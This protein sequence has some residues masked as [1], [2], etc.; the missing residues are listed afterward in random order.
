MNVGRNNHRL[1]PLSRHGHGPKLHHNV[2]PIIRDGGGFQPVSKPQ[3]HTIKFSS[4]HWAAHEPSVLLAAALVG[5]SAG[6]AAT[7]AARWRRR[8]VAKTLTA[9]PRARRHGMALAASPPGGQDSEG[10]FQQRLQG[11]SLEYLGMEPSGDL[12]AIAL[13]YFVQG[14][15][16]LAE[17]ATSFYL[18]DALHLDPAQAASLTGIAALPWVVKPLWGFLSDSVPLFGSRRRNY[19][20]LCGVLGATGWL[21][22]ATVVTGPLS[23]GLALTCSSLGVAAAD[24]VVDSLVVERSRHVPLAQAGALQSLCWGS[25]AI[26]SVLAAYFAGTLVQTCGAQFVF[27]VTALFPLLTVAAAFSVHETPVKPSLGSTTSKLKEQMG[28]LWDAI[29]QPNILLPTAFVVL[30]QATPSASTAMFYFTTNQLGFDAQ[31]L[32]QVA[33]FSSLASLF[34]V[35]LYNTKLKSLPLKTVFLWTALLGTVLGLSQLLLVT[36]YNRQL[37]L[38]D[39]LF[40]LGDSVILTVLGQVAFM[41]ILVLAAR[42]CPPGIEA[43]L[44]AGLMSLFNG[45]GIFSRQL[46]ATLTA[47]LGVTSTEFQNLA[48]LLVICNL[49]SLLPLPFLRLLDAVPDEEPEEPT[50]AT[51]ATPPEADGV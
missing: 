17:L 12:F 43:T 21:A 18:K 30:W 22:M 35:T 41:P 33:F 34:G 40:S 29:R 15:L 11:L 44:F 38:S 20:A 9:L 51:D 6:L 25:R 49:S 42:I 4:F 2:V 19:L 26:G 48:L 10:T 8:G 27:A 7:A 24:V 13:V 50:D 32:G 45:A 1:S 14:A 46:G 36:G 39:Q 31:F 3:N 47:A 28:T 16:G 5:L 37:G 23:A